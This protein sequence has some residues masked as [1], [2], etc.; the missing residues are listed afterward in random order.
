M[1][2]EVRRVFS[3]EEG[4]WGGCWAAGDRLFINPGV[5]TSQAVCLWF[6]HLTYVSTKSYFKRRRSRTPPLLSPTLP[7]ILQILDLADNHLDQMR[8]PGSIGCQES[9]I[10]ILYPNIYVHKTY[11]HF[12][13]HSNGSHGTLPGKC[14][15]HCG[16]HWCM[17]VTR[18]IKPAYR[19][20][21]GLGDHLLPKFIPQFLL[22]Q[23]LL[24]DP[25]PSGVLYWK[26]KSTFI[27]NHFIT[28][29]EHSFITRG[30]E[31]FLQVV[32]Y[33]LFLVINRELLLSICV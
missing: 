9:L 31:I 23:V 1:V 21:H 8:I 10:S 7:S 26:R 20:G 5:L 29:T 19:T 22:S 11:K 33:V 24:S 12:F 13:F 17:W 6:V 3:F 15:V 16:D 4:S 14:T 2:M 32:F 18:G 30:S 25:A 28:L 27:D